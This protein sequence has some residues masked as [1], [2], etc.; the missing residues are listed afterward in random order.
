M[1]L[2]KRPGKIQWKK[3]GIYKQ[4]TISITEKTHKCKVMKLLI[5]QYILLLVVL[6][7]IIRQD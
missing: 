7:D 4:L 6:N 2:L 3:Y 5:L 1:N